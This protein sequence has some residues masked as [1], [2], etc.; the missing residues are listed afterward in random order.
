M[1][2]IVERCV[3]SWFYIDTA[4]HLDGGSPK[5]SALKTFG[6]LCFS[7][8]QE[9][10]IHEIMKLFHD[11]SYDMF[12]L[13]LIMCMLRLINCRSLGVAQ[14]FRICLCS[15]QWLGSN[16]GN[17]FFKKWMHMQTTTGFMIDIFIPSFTPH[18]CQ[19]HNWQTR[20]HPVALGYCPRTTK[21]ALSACFQWP[22]VQGSMS[23][24]LPK[25][26]TVHPSESLKTWT[27]PDYS[28]YSDVTGSS[29]PGTLIPVKTSSEPATLCGTH[30]VSKGVKF[31]GSFKCLTSCYPQK[32]G[33]SSRP[34]LSSLPIKGSYCQDTCSQNRYKH[35]QSMVSRNWCQWYLYNPLH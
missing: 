28:T 31:S 4:W 6:L 14:A 5:G 29:C 13:P 12:Q 17:H 25:K 21:R 9:N 1:L 18:A 34:K 11:V 32:L 26:K 35:R 10:L 30:L 20:M 15:W 19:L 3:T 24:F 7:L 27:Y 8:G 2:S 33:S 23:Q 22:L 16:N